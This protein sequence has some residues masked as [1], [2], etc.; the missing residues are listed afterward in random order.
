MADLEHETHT[1]EEREK[2]TKWFIEG[3]KM[4]RDATLV[5]LGAN[6]DVSLDDAIS[7]FAEKCR[8]QATDEAKSTECND[9]PQNQ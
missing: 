7:A 3:A 5:K 9:I 6:L 4:Q 2:A 1:D 8:M